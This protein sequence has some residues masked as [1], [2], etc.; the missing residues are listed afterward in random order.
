MKSL[1]LD[2]IA[3]FFD[4]NSPMILTWLK[5]QGMTQIDLQHVLDDEEN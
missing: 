3:K 4:A 5:E 2:N 1:E